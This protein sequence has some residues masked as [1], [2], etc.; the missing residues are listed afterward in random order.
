MNIATIKCYIYHCRYNL[1]YCLASLL[2][3]Q[4]QMMVNGHDGVSQYH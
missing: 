3:G 2:V 1:I 4:R